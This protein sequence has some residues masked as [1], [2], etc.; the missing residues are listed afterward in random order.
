M[1]KVVISLSRTPERLEKFKKI[2][3]HLAD[4]ERFEAKNGAH[5]ERGILAGRGLI[6]EDLRYSDGALGCALS[7]LA[8]WE[9]SVKN[10]EYL[11][12]LEDDAIVHKKFQQ[13]GCL[14]DQETPLG[15]DMIVWGWNF[16]CP[17]LFDLM[18]GISPC[19]AV[20]SQEN[21]STSWQTFQD[22]DLAPKSYPLT[23][24]FGTPAYSI[25][26]IGAE[27]LLKGLLPLRNFTMS[28]AQF[29]AKNK[30]LDVALNT[31][32]KLTNSYVCFP[33]LAITENNKELSTVF[34]KPQSEA[35]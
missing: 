28:T 12:I 9:R 2:N 4:V 31:I 14:I 5:E 7:H 33:P 6:S 34:S 16:D 22:L 8:L 20:F 25:S 21:L 30:G 11:T 35:S 17:V 27:K 32:Y 3:E 24:C 26:P 1:K 15:W 29:E 18:P 10:Q 13:L 23:Y 19:Q